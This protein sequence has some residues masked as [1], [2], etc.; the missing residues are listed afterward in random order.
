MWLPR[1]NQLA[2]EARTCM[3]LDELPHGDAHLLLNRHR[4]VDM[5]TDAEQLGALHTRFHGRRRL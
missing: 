1:H 2:V 5:P 3:P 4:P